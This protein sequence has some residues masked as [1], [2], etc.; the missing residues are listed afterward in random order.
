[1]KNEKPPAIKDPNILIFTAL[2]YLSVASGDTVSY[3]IFHSYLDDFELSKSKLD[4]AL[5][6]FCEQG[7]LKFVK[8]KN[9]F[10]I[11]W[12]LNSWSEYVCSTSNLTVKFRAI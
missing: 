11:I 8:T 1:M 12:N 10:E 6:L 9:H 2:N 7:A 5:F 3:G 4:H